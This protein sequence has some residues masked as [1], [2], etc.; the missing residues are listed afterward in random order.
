M[1]EEGNIIVRKAKVNNLKDVTVEI[2]R[3]LE[4]SE[5]T[6][7]SQLGFISLRQALNNHE[8]K[9]SATYCCGDTVLW[10]VVV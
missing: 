9:S 5:Y 3:R 8:E 2:P 7:N 10:V 4:A 1:K 6:L